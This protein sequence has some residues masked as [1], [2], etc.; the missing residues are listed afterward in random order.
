MKIKRAKSNFHFPCY[1]IFIYLKPPP[2][3]NL[4]IAS[5]AVGVVV[6]AVITAVIRAHRGCFEGPY[7]FSFFFFL[8]SFFLFFFSLETKEEE[9][10]NK[11]ISD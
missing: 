2:H 1:E 9:K 3:R 4:L 6:G 10:K 5:P 7:L 11:L 8:F